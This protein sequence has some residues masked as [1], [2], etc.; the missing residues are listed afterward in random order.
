M[1]R[2]GKLFVISGP[3]AVGKGTLVKA[4][5]NT[6]PDLKLSISATTRKMREGEV[7]GESYF[8]KSE[9]EFQLMI[10]EGAF[11]EYASVHGMHYGTPKTYVDEMLQLGKH[12][13]LEIDPQ[14]ALQI[15]Q[16]KQDAILIFITPPSLGTLFDR[17]KKRGTETE[18]QIEKRMQSA[19]KEFR[20]LPQYDYVVEN[21]EIELA[22]SDLK[23]I[24]RAEDLRV[25][26]TNA[27]IVSIIKD[28]EERGTL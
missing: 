13:I 15:R 12:V 19:I 25:V 3:T 28:L 22:L 5:I 26:E 10:R 6:D 7:D 18:E 9:E 16:M 14:G 11:L 21:D 8:F 4:L 23:A 17:L 27:R 20:L 2:E 24:F 1:R